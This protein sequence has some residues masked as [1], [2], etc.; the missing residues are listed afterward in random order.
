VPAV[1]EELA[2]TQ[3]LG[4]QRVESDPERTVDGVYAMW[5]G[6]G[7]GVDRAGDALK[8]GNAYGSSPHGGVLVVAGDDHG[9]VS[10]S[11]PHQ[12]DHAFMAWRMP[13]MQPASVAEYLEFGLYGYELSR[14][15]GAW[16][17]MAALSE[18]VESA[19][20]VD[21]DAVNARVAAWEDADAVRAATGHAAPPDGLHYRW[22]DLPSLRIESR[23]EDKLAAV[24]AFTQ[25]N[26]ID[27]HV[28][29]SPH[30]KV[31]IVTCGK[32]HHDL[33]EVLRR[34]ELSPEQLA[35]AGVRLYKVGLSFPLE[36]TR[37]KAFAQGLDEILIVEEKGAVV[38]TQL[39]DIFYNAPPDARPVLVGKH[40]RDGQPLVSALASCARRASS[41]WWRTGWPCTSPTT[42]TWATTCSMCAT[43][44]R[45]SCWATRATPS[46][47]CRTSAPAART[48][49][50]PRCPRARPRARASAATSWPTGWTAAPRA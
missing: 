30:A 44:R 37:L 6:K 26:S 31:G 4:T 27:R 25:R 20:T 2:A 33:M 14:Y 47:A 34:L 49:P 19:G 8:H 43:S 32:A 22:P 38:E 36:Q 15:S 5:Y 16:V 10:S 35:R 24:A 29:V 28:I 9:C 1:N 11:M 50:A 21:L 48:T 18:I 46:S 12:S 39:R 17:G 40:D 45:P 42:T 23:L 13:V 7:P 3:V 41:S